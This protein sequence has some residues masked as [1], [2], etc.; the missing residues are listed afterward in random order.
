MSESFRNA[1]LLELIAEVR[2][3]PPYATVPTVQPGVQV[4]LPIGFGSIQIDNFLHQFG[5]E[6]YKRGFQRMERVY[7]SGL[8]IVQG[9]T[10]ARYRSD[11]P[12]SKTVIYQVG[13][14][15]FSAN[16]IA[17]YRTWNH[18]RPKVET[19]IEV[20]LATREE[21]EKTVPFNPVSLRYIDSFKSDLSGGRDVAGFLS[22]VLKI[23]VNLPNAISQHLAAGK[24]P[25]PY[26][27]LAIPSE[28]G[29]L[30]LNVGEALVNGENT[31]LLDMTFSTESPIMPEKSAIMNAFDTAHSIIHKTFV[32]L[33]SPIHDLMQLEK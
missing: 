22:E 16:A 17:P 21:S 28:K 19:G 4:S 29:I 9:Q 2:W 7:P 25:K 8:P 20:L 18:F 1:P 12:D 3:Q 11:S 32:E 24:S 26:V 15:L 30:R 14:G 27:M 31:I 13:A 10:I 6:V 33:T 23:H 5:G